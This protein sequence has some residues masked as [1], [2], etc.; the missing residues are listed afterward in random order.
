MSVLV[1][2][3]L[4]S[5]TWE[6]QRRLNSGD[7]KGALTDVAQRWLPR[8]AFA[9]SIMA[10]GVLSSSSL[11]LGSRFFSSGWSMGKYMLG[12]GLTHAAFTSMQQLMAEDRYSRYQ[13]SADARFLA[14]QQAYEDRWNRTQT[15]YDLR[16]FQLTEYQKESLALQWANFYQREDYYAQKNLYDK[17][18]GG[19]YARDIDF[20][21]ESSKLMSGY[22]FLGDLTY[23][24]GRGRIKDTS[25]LFVGL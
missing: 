2:T 7:I 10:G 13:A 11:G 9:S 3:G 1:G 24:S 12:Y 14:N 4:D 23:K 21:S 25:S 18:Y 15:Q 16:A 20:Y 8:F 22:A 6:F 5:D 19:S 17:F